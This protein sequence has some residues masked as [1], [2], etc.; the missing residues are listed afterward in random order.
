MQTD[1][2]LEILLSYI[3]EHR[4]KEGEMLPPERKLAEVLAISRRDLRAALATLE[5]TGRVWRGVGR[6]T[7]LGSR[8]SKFSPTLR[9][10][11]V[12]TSPADVAEMRLIVEPELAALAAMKAS[13][14]DL[15]EL[16]KCAKR[17]VAAKDDEDWQHWDHRFHLL[18]AKATRN[19]AIIALLEAINGVR[20][21]PSLRRKT[22]DQEARRQFGLQHQAI[23]DAMVARDSKGAAECMRQHLSRVQTVHSQ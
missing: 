18:I 7:Y 11:S 17:N 12:G 3:S 13:P 21:K 20:I 6:G 8:P 14:E 4:I 9:G 5:S 23:V 19:P 2:T 16:Q 10:M 22:A 15:E 1:S